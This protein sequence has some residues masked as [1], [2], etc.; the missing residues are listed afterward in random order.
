MRRIKRAVY[1]RCAGLKNTLIKTTSFSALRLC[2]KALSN[3]PEPLLSS[4][5]RFQF[6]THEQTLD[7]GNWHDRVGKNGG[8]YGAPASAAWTSRHRI[9]PFARGYFGVRA[10]W[11][12]PR[13]FAGS[14]GK[15]V[16]GAP[17]YLD[18]GAR[19]G[20]GG[21]HACCACAAAR[22][23]RCPD[24]RRQFRLSQYGASRRLR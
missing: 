8:Q 17:A 19:R 2:V 11:R 20:A 10:I 4:Q 15:S 24:R 9:R 18:D 6:F 5:E 23:R 22:R 7:N 14:P 21:R 3:K 12:D 1:F 13:R 16:R